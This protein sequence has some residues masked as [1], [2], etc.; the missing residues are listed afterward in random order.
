M[1]GK[2]PEPD[3]E[4]YVEFA[5]AYDQALGRR[6]FSSLQPVL[7]SVLSRYPN[8]ARTHL[9]LACGTGLAVQHFRKRGFRSLGVDASVPMLSLAR[10]R[11]SKVLAGDLRKLPVVGTFGLL[12]CLYDSLNHMLEWDDLLGAFRG[13]RPLLDPASILLFDVNHPS[14][15]PRI[16]GLSEPFVSA[17]K[18][19]KLVIDTRFFPEARRGVAEI[20]GWARMNGVQVPIAETHRQRAW[21]LEEIRS[22][23]ETAGLAVLEEIDFDPFLESGGEGGVKVVFIAARR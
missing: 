4:A 9:D 7:D 14:V 19:H 17:G 16:W 23:L 13:C 3:G 1:T 12:T 18:D 20:S 21:L 11:G 5:F 2:L 22:A 10:K 6:F 15:Y 8:L